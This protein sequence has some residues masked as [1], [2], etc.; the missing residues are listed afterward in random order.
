MT[1]ICNLKDITLR[2]RPDKSP[3]VRVDWRP[4]IS[5]DGASSSAQQR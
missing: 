1:N 5:F 3:L 4:I 2:R